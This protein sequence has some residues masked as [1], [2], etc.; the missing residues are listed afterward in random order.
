MSA[1]HC[2]FGCLNSLVLFGATRAYS[3]AFRGADL[4]AR[5]LARTST[6]MFPLRFAIN[7]FPPVRATCAALWRTPA[8]L[9]PRARSSVAEAGS[10]A[11]ETPRAQKAGPAGRVPRGCAGARK[12]KYLFSPFYKSM[13]K[14]SNVCFFVLCKRHWI[15]RV[16][17][18]HRGDSLCIPFTLTLTLVMPSYR[19]YVY[20]YMTY[21]KAVSGGGRGGKRRT[22][23]KGPYQPRPVCSSLA[24]SH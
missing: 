1:C 18:A 4:L 8:V 23:A 6:W 22:C 24:T 19:L 7:I 9:L 11:A 20:Y 16:P 14:Q 2:R 21:E 15:N 13:G 5:P 3:A 10:D 12:K 17:G